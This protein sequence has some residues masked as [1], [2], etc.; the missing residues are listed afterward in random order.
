MKKSVEATD[1][2]REE[3]WK[4]AKKSA[5]KTFDVPKPEKLYNKYTQAAINTLIQESYAFSSSYLE[6]EEDIDNK[7][8]QI[9]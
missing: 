6:K 1:K 8:S 2:E 5:G 7:T 3:L 9:A 4:R